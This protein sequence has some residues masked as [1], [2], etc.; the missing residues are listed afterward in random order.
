MVDTNLLG[1][2]AGSL[3]TAAFIP[4]VVKTWQSKSAEDIS[5]AMFALF[6]LGVFLWLLYGVAIGAMPIILTNAV[7][8][9]LALS[10]IIMKM[11]FGCNS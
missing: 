2:L 4:Q 3:T 9:V 11:R 1:L 5:Y 7:T 10:I 8:L 6:S